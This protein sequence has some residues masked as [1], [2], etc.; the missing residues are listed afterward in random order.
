MP[1]QLLDITWPALV[2][3]S[4]TA[5]CWCHVLVSGLSEIKFNESAFDELVLDAKRKRLINALVK[6]GGEQFEDII[7]GKQGG[8]I[9]L[10]HGPPGVGKTLTAEAIAEV[11]HRPLYY[12]TMGELGKVNNNS[13]H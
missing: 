7:Q 11:L 8:S 3:F 4:F 1:S 13:R 6:F 12:V 10:L 2:G 5:K 9:F